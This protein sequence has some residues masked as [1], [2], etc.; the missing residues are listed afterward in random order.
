M[1]KNTYLN[2]LGFND[3]LIF[4]S[5]CR[6]LSRKKNFSTESAAWLQ[7][8][9]RYLDSRIFCPTYKDCVSGAIF[10]RKSVISKWIW[11][12]SNFSKKFF[13]SLEHVHSC[14]FIIA[15]SLFLQQKLQLSGGRE[16]GREDC[17]S[18]QLF[19]IWFLWYVELVI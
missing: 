10:I 17:H 13:A 2:K 14:S 16:W 12:L 18:H 1:K 4:V 19:I 5:R 7:I 9:K 6:K 3:L 11:T 15:T 8:L